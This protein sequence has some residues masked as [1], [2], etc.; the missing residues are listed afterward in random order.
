[1]VVEENKKKSVFA[2][3]SPDL[4]SAALTLRLWNCV[5]SKE[6][7][8]NFDINAFENVLLS[9]FPLKRNT[10]VGLVFVSIICD[11]ILFDVSVCKQ[12]RSQN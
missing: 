3:F 5:S 1:M 12:Y 7:L 10:A 9:Y 11:F 2:I 8:L 6:E 4:K